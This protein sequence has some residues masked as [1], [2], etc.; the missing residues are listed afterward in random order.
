MARLALYCLLSTALLLLS[1]ISRPGFA[2]EADL[3]RHYRLAGG[4]RIAIRVYGEDDLTVESRLGESGV[5]NFPLLG[6]LRVTGLTAGEL[7]QLVARRLK[8]PYL[9]DPVV[10]VN[11]TEY[12]PF[13]VNGEVNEPGAI[14]FQPGITLRKAVAMSGGF[15]ERAKRGEL[16]VISSGDGVGKPRSAGLDELVRPGDIITVKQSFF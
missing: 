14:P 8:G 7:E 15:T 9:V 10:S 16:Q 3:E 4:D 11:I 6:E 13:F 12:R 1:L 5:I 2:S